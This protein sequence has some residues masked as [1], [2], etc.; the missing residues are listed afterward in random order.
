M[1]RMRRPEGSIRQRADGRFEVRVQTGINYDTGA[2]I[3]KSV[4]VRS[5]EEARR[6]LHRML[7][8]PA[9]AR[10]LDAENCTLTE[11]LESWLK[12]YVANNVRQSTFNSYRTYVRNHFAPVLGKCRLKDI[13]PRK[14]QEFYNFKQEKGNLS[15][16]TIINM[17]L[18]LHKALDQA[19][20]EGLLE[21]NPA[22]ALN[23]KRGRK[24]QIEVLT[25]DQQATLLRESRKHRY[26]VFIRLVLATGLRMGELVGLMWEDIDFRL[27]VLHV[28]RSLGRLTKMDWSDTIKP[29]TQGAIIIR[30]RVLQM[31]QKYNAEYKADVL[32]MAEE[33][34]V[35]AACRQ[36]GISSK[37]VYNWRRAERI[38]KGEIRGVQPG[39]TPEQAV[40]RLTRE[41]RELQE[42]NYILRKALG[43][44][45]GR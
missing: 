45:A 31:G 3:R 17:N 26:G 21:S 22:S 41:I 40:V 12:T 13:S 14:L 43:F 5:E 16:K 7:A 1:A 18:C 11:W 15:P 8:E 34:G 29:H 38:A 27:G 19:V 6:L 37:T 32:K 20:K 30:E 9:L 25:R 23:L 28:R 2:P 42:A 33:I 4:Y 39:E 44:M 24:P 35:S 10:K 36:L